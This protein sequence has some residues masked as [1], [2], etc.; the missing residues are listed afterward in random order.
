MSSHDRCIVFLL[1][2]FG[3][4]PGV[5]RF[6]NVAYNNYKLPYHC[7]YPLDYLVTPSAD[8]DNDGIPDSNFGSFIPKI[9]EVQTLVSVDMT[10]GFRVSNRYK[11]NN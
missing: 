1:T 3:K 6:E 11:F 7:A 9:S 4:N 5:I 8:T 10:K 2:I